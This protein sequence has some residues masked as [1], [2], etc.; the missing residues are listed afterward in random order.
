M[1]LLTIIILGLMA[2]FNQ[3]QRAFRLGMTQ[4]DVL[5][6]GRIVTD[7]V[8]RELEQMTPS[9]LSGANPN[10]GNFYAAIINSLPPPGPFATPATYFPFLQPLPGGNYVRTNVLEDV[11]FLTRENQAWTAVGYFVRTN[12]V[13]AGGWE[14]VGTLYRFE[15]QES[16]RQFPYPA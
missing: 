4:T 1:G 5:E 12:P 14:P 15:M 9:D 13:F 8:G 16:T 11:F 7:M 2:M 10:G 6:S 3:T